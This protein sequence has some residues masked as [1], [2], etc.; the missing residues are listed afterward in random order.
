MRTFR[1]AVAFVLVLC[2]V[3]GAM[4]RETVKYFKYKVDDMNWLPVYRTELQSLS[5]NNGTG[6]A[7]TFDEAG[8]AV[9]VRY[10]IHGNTLSDKAYAYD[11]EGRPAEEREYAPEGDA[12]RSPERVNVYDWDGDTLKAV[13]TFAGDKLLWD[14]RREESWG[15]VG[16]VKYFPDG[17]EGESY[18]F[19]EETDGIVTKYKWRLS[20]KKYYLRT[21]D[22][23]TGQITGS[24]GYIKGKYDHRQVYRYND[25]G[26]ISARDSYDRKGR[27]YC[28]NVFDDM[29]NRIESSY[30]Y[31]DNT[32]QKYRWTL[33]PDGTMEGLAVTI[34][35]KPAYTV[36]YIRRPS[37]DIEMSEVYDGN[38]ELFARYPNNAVQ[39]LKKD[40]SSESGYKG[41]ILK[42]GK[43]W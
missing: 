30:R 10:C 34:N 18:L 13:H 7:V 43:L 25:E 22:P 16:Y 31:R 20:G 15:D 1:V 42:S 37:G 4:A 32:R 3:S 33:N 40:G 9:A 5:D 36:K 21:V 29:G 11:A 6:Y 2:L 27:Q 19:T 14:W 12:G 23:A 17:S 41:E 26:V 8:R 28:W 24:R 35:G 38:G 39:Y